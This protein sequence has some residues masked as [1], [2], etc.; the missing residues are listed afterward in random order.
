[1]KLTNLRVREYKSI[2]DSGD[3]AVSDVT[4]LVGKNEAGKTALLE[5]LY[6]L[7]PINDKDSKFSVTHDYPRS[8]VEDYEQAIEAAIGGTIFKVW[9]RAINR[10][11]RTFF[12]I[13]CRLVQ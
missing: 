10:A 5:A 6:K 3:V 12:R 7:N 9:S 4:C 8:D 1:M 13:V 2:R 11:R